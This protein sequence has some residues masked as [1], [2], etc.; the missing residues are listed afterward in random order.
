[1][2]TRAEGPVKLGYTIEYIRK[3]STRGDVDIY[4][5]DKVDN[6]STVEDLRGWGTCIQDIH[7][8]DIYRGRD[9]YIQY[10]MDHDDPTGIKVG[11]GVM[12]TIM[13][14]QEDNCRYRNEGWEKADKKRQ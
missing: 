12:R 6:Y 5:A 11:I 9:G 8:K 10:H 13:G 14:D 4:H 2:T 1:M 3:R 7:K